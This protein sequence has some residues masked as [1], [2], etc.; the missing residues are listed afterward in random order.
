MV[1]ALV[2]GL[3]TAGCSSNA[4]PPSGA[5]G[6]P[7][8]GGRASGGNASGGNAG[9]GGAL[10]GGTQGLGGAPA[11]G[12]ASGGG[13]SSTTKDAALDTPIGADALAQDDLRTQAARPELAPD[14]C[15]AW[16]AT[17]G[18]CCAQYCQSDNKSENCDK[19]G[20]P[21]SAECQVVNAKACTSGQWPEV[22]AVSDSEPWHYSRSTH[23]GT[24][25]TGACAFGLYG[26]CS[27]AMKFTDPAMQAKCDV[28]C[29]AY[30][31][32]CTDPSGVSLRG[33]F[34]APQGNY[35]T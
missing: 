9:S 7:G 29:K 33:N 2:A 27:T 4:T 5:G 26:L 1:V 15:G 19:C 34:A 21:G 12:G 23:F 28:F 32:L 20:G 22:H 3:G 17:E 35:Y 11:T 18:V 6:T 14:S 13:G 25:P 16:A 24:A 8:S 31:D 30:P 10:N